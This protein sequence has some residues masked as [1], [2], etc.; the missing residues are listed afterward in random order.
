MLYFINFN[1]LAFTKWEL[2]SQG[3]YHIYFINI[4][5]KSSGI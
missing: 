3:P 1:V 5:P 4:T 2:F